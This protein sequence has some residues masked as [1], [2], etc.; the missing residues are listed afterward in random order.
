MEKRVVSEI[1]LSFQE[2]NKSQFHVN[3]NELTNICTN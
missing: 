1:Y 2:F 3:V